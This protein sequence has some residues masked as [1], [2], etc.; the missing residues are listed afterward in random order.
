MIIDKQK[1]TTEI[2]N[3]LTYSDDATTC[4]T[5]ASTKVSTSGK[6]ACVTPIEN[7]VNYSD[8]GNCTSCVPSLF[9]IAEKQKCGTEIL[10]CL[11]YSDD[12]TTCVTCVQSKVLTSGKKACANEIANCINYT[13]DKKCSKCSS[14]T[15][16]SNDLLGCVNTMDDCITYT[17]DGLCSQCLPG[18][19]LA[20]NKSVCLLPS[21]SSDP[22]YNSSIY[23][24]VSLNFS[25]LTNNSFLDNGNSHEISV[26]LTNITNYKVA[27]KNSSVKFTSVKS[28]S[29]MIIQIESSQNKDSLGVLNLKDVPKDYY[30]CLFGLNLNKIQNR[31]LE[32]NL[33]TSS[34]PDSFS[35]TYQAKDTYFIGSKAEIQKEMSGSSGS[36]NHDDG[37]GFDSELFAI[38]FSIFGFIFVVVVILVV[39]HFLKKKN[40]GKNKDKK[41]EFVQVPQSP[42][43]QTQV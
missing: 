28:N 14:S 26:T 37:N 25:D 20:G 15:T 18:A 4:V 1:C 19:N 38:L 17:S 36:T 41:T 30:R 32:Q 10:N 34:L 7:C 40:L 9:L 3:C 42:D 29:S 33:D 21:N 2:L 16:L 43:G 5:C 24:R 13:D 11:N 6:K 22:S 8:D 23:S 12:V 39:R 31:I 35:L 27:L